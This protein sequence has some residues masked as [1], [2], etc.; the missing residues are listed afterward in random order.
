MEF[1]GPPP[2][3]RDRMA[4]AVARVC[5]LAGSLERHPGR[6]ERAETLARMLRGDRT[7]CP[8]AGYAWVPKADCLGLCRPVTADCLRLKG[9]LSDGPPRDWEDR[10]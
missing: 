5:R 3:G 8:M 7:P 4:E 2:Y 6:E 1:L 10:A 9:R